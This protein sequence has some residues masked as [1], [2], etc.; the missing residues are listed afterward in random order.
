VVSIKIVKTGNGQ[1]AKTKT[2]IAETLAKR[3]LLQIIQ[4][5]FNNINVKLRKSILILL[6]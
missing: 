2:D 3:T 6:Q 1:Y 5:N 4:M